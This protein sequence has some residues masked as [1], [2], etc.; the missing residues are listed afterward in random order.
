MLHAIATPAT[1]SYYHGAVHGCG[2]VVVGIDEKASRLIIAGG[3]VGQGT[4]VVGHQTTD[5]SQYSIGHRS[6]NRYGRILPVTVALDRKTGL[7]YT[8]AIAAAPRTA[9]FFDFDG[10]LSVSMCEASHI[11]CRRLL[12][13]SCL[14]PGRLTS[15]VPPCSIAPIKRP[16]A[17]WSGLLSACSSMQSPTSRAATSSRASHQLRQSTTSAARSGWLSSWRSSES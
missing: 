10:T 2:G 5:L 15:L 17:P 8:S 11:A 6:R 14:A 12:V 3:P 7:V 16:L 9:F 13:P 1:S 4:P